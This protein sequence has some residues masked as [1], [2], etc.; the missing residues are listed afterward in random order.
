M[1]LLGAINYD[2]TTAAT[3]ATSSLIAMTAVDT[4][5]LR[6]TVT[7]PASGKIWCRLRCSWQGSAA[8]WRILFGVMSGATVVARCA[9]EITQ[10]L[11][12][13]YVMAEFMITGL[14][15]GA[16]Y[17]LDAAYSVEVVLA[18]AT[19]NY[20]G[21]D[22]ATTN[23]AWGGFIY[24]LWDPQPIAIAAAA[25]VVDANGRLDISKIEG[26]DAT[27]QIR[28][29]VVSDATRFAGA[30]VASIK[31][32]TDNL[33]A[34]PAAVGSAMTLAADAIN[35]AAYALETGKKVVRS[36][37]L[38]AG[39]IAG[40]TLDAG[41]SAVNSFYV[42]ALLVITGGTGAGQSREITAYVGATKVFTIQH[43]WATTPTATSTFAIL[44]AHQ[45]KVDS[46]LQV[47]DSTAATINGK[48]GTPAN[49]TVSA[50][51]AAVKD[52]TANIRGKTDNLP[53]DTAAEIAAIPADV[54][55]EILETGFDASRILRI[56]AAAVA[57]KSTGGTFRNLADDEDQITGTATVTGD[58][59]S[60]SYGS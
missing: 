36:G 58:R 41:A 34:S 25:I 33:P 31:A 7:A 11:T 17:T 23:D 50:D 26:T 48:I 47:V 45:P 29:A 1:N 32:K 46:S 42:G 51:I 21:P 54:W 43:I 53:A 52:D 12:G 37:T 18:S 3:K 30:S 10:P 13:G 28:D 16:S 40:G 44:P 15:P 39:T 55:A 22:N 35:D 8:T 2:P 9:P 6:L 14:T 27:D 19:L 24:E 38:A 4:T 56:A 57:G 49:V 5:N 60:V 20:G 59:T